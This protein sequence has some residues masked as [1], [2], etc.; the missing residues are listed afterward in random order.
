MILDSSPYSRQ[1]LNRAINLASV[2]G[3]FAYVLPLIIDARFGLLLFA[4]IIGLPIAFAS[5]WVIGRP[6]LKRLMRKPVSWVS[7]SLFG[8]IVSFVIAA[9]GIL[10]GRI[11]GY[12]ISKDPNFSSRI[13]GGEFTQSVDGILTPYGWLILAQNTAI[14]VIWGIIVAL[15]VRAVIG[16]GKQQ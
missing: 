12:R 3:W 9:V 14:F 13:G 2:L 15:I 4:A 7:A 8:G 5:C 16:P 6:I 10:L 1:E 11:N